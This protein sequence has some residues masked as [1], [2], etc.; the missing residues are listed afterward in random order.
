MP[1]FKVKMY[2]EREIVVNAEDWER[3]ADK[4]R[5]VTGVDF[6]IESVEQVDVEVYRTVGR[7]VEIHDRDNGIVIGIDTERTDGAW[8]PYIT[9]RELADKLQTYL[10]QREDD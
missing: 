5:A 10:D 8:L 7:I 9:A 2:Q 1:K 3:A 4:A 6:D